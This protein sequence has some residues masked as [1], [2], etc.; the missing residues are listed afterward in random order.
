M[1]FFF[2]ISFARYDDV[3]T[4]RAN[5][6]SVTLRARL[7]YYYVVRARFSLVYRRRRRWLRTNYARARATVGN[8]NWGRRQIPKQK[9]R[10][11]KKRKTRNP[12][13]QNNSTTASSR[14]PRV[15]VHSEEWAERAE[16]LYACAWPLWGLG[17]VANEEILLKNSDPATRTMLFGFAVFTN[18]MPAQGVPPGFGLINGK[19]SCPVI[20]NE[21]KPSQVYG[22]PHR[23]VPRLYW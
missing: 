14:N 6:H 19:L 13:A 2:S 20:P 22:V 18:A 21:D 10:K 16:E 1:V 5:I 23:A 15:R 3:I 17:A 7:L 12:F 9:R 11:K 4:M 8:G